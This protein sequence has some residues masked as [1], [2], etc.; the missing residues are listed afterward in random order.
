[1]GKVPLE[2][3]RYNEFVEFLEKHF[4]CHKDQWVSINLVE[5]IYT[6]CTHQ[7]TNVRLLTDTDIGSIILGVGS[8]IGIYKNKTI[9]GHLYDRN[10]IIALIQVIRSILSGYFELPE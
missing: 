2:K 1:M 10:Q 9:H 4:W 7:N 6:L 8:V 3:S 5:R